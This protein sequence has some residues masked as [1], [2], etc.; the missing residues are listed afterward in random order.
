MGWTGDYSSPDNFFYP[1]FGP[2]GTQDIGNW[3]DETLWKLL[4]KARATPDVNQR[5]QIYA[6]ASD[7]VYKS[8]LRIPIV[9]SQALLAQRQSLKGWVP[10]P[11]GIEPFAELQK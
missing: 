1:H 10:S 2:G 4:E 5:N 9:H 11:L 8:A 6:E 7:I 3:K